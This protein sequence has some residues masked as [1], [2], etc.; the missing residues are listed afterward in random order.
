MAQS[1]GDYCT[2]A[3]PSGSNDNNVARIESTLVKERKVFK[4]KAGSGR[5]DRVQ[6][7]RRIRCRDP[8]GS[9][10]RRDV[11]AVRWVMTWTFALRTIAD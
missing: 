4:R 3:R 1:L 7:W 2:R 11:L 9:I 8:A 6:Q 5:R 10:I